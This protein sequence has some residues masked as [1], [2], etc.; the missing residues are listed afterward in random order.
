MITSKHRK[1][2]LL[3]LNRSI[4]GTLVKAPTK[5]TDKQLTD[6][7]KNNVITTKNEGSVNFKHKNG[8]TA[9]YKLTKPIKK[10]V[11]KVTKVTKVKNEPKP[12]RKKPRP[13]RRITKTTNYKIPSKAQKAKKVKKVKKPPLPPLPPRAPPVPPKKRNYRKKAPPVPPKPKGKKCNKCNKGNNKC[14]KCKKGNNKCMAQK[15]IDTHGYK[16]FDKMC[17]GKGSKAKFAVSRNDIRNNSCKELANTLTWR[18]LKS[19]MAKI[20]KPSKPTYY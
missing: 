12:I 19:S 8:F 11:A 14:N 2:F 15:F 4:R 16:K 1:K 9:S 5:M 17:A 18:C 13:R 10:R 7:F 20:R 6:Y 3:A